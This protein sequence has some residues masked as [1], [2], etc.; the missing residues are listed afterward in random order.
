MIV[1]PTGYE[2]TL[3]VHLDTIAVSSSL[4]DIKLIASESLRVRSMLEQIHIVLR[5][6]SLLQVRCELPTPVTWNAE[7]V[8]SIAVFLRQP[9]L[10]LLRDHI[11]M[12]TDLAKDWVSGPPTDHQ[13]FIPMIYAFRFEMHHFTLNLYANDQNIVDKPLIKEENGM[14]M[15]FFHC[16]R[17]CSSSLALISVKGPHWKTTVNI[18]SNVFRPE[19]TAVPIS[20]VVPDVVASISL[21][22][23]NTHAL[24]LPPEGLTVFR[25]NHMGVDA[26]YEYFSSVHEDHLDQLRISLDVSNAVEQSSYIV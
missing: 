25:A 17:F 1:G 21:P 13:K 3:E 8:W 12:F 4:N 11:N 16:P 26:S 19:S 2:P 18:L 24:Y 20:T 22:R 5:V 6:M 14:I 15:S 9:I 10:F 23:W 7:R